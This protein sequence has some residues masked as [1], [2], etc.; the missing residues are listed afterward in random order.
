MSGPEENT[1]ATD[2]QGQETEGVRVECTADSRAHDLDVRWTK[3]AVFE[4]DAVADAEKWV[5][6][7]NRTVQGT[8]FLAEAPHSKGELPLDYQLKYRQPG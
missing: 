6:H 8:L 2:G 4:F 1:T 5:A 7:Q 3:G